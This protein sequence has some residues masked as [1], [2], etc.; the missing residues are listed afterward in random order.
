MADQVERRLLRRR[1]GRYFPAAG[2]DPHHEVDIRGTAGGSAVIVE[3]TG[4]M[5]GSTKPA[6]LREPC[7]RARSTFIRATATWSTC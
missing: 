3:H 1:G 2:I 5:V 4:R 7:T 6:A